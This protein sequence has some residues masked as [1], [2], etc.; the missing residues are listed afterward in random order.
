[1]PCHTNKNKGRRDSVEPCDRKHQERRPHRCST[2][3]RGPMAPEAMPCRKPAHRRDHLGS[4]ESECYWYWSG[5]GSFQEQRY[6]PAHRRGHLWSVESE[7][8]WYWS[9][10]GSFQEQRHHDGA[11]AETRRRS[12]ALVIIGRRTNWKTPAQY[13]IADGGGT[14]RIVLHR[15][16]WA[17]MLSIR[18]DLWAR[19]GT[20]LGVLQRGTR[21]RIRPRHNLDNATAGGGLVAQLAELFTEAPQLA[22]DYAR[23]RFSLVGVY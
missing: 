12:R 8:Y 21:V 19:L 15:L 17:S 1:M 2:L 23:D 13:Y 7:C 16:R 11:T 5:A 9:G 10:A 20:G 4:E 6:K 14:R 3:P 18:G 22:E